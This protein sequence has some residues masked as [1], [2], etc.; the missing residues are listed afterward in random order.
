MDTKF[1]FKNL[2]KSP[3]GIVARREYMPKYCLCLYQRISAIIPSLPVSVIKPLCLFAKKLFVNQLLYFHSLCFHF[4]HDS[5]FNICRTRQTPDAPLCYKP[6]GPEA[7]GHVDR[8]CA[9]FP[10]GT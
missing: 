6:L 4:C 10:G 3:K 5:F 8:S 1:M 7:L 2:Y 9:V